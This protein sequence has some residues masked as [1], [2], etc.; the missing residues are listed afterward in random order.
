MKRRIKRLCS[1]NTLRTP[2]TYGN[3]RQLDLKEAFA[4]AQAAEEPS[5]RNTGKSVST[6]KR[7]R[8]SRR[9]KPDN[10]GETSKR[11]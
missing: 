5:N 8:K 11:S 3:E 2:N 6:A 1:E 10:S 9:K 4:L 7:K